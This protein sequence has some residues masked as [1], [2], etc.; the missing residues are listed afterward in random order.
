M[1]PIHK[2]LWNSSWA[3]ISIYVA[4]I[5]PDVMAKWLIALLIVYNIYKYK[6]KLSKWWRQLSLEIFET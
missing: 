6:D 2:F 4:K 1:L 3:I 5:T